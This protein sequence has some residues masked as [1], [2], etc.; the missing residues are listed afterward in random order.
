MIEPLT[1]RDLR[2][3]GGAADA[4]SDGQLVRLPMT[5]FV[6]RSAGA[7][8]AI[9]GVIW[10]AGRPTGNFAMTDAF[11]A[12]SRSRWVHRY[13]VQVLEAVQ[14]FEPVIYA[15]A[16]DFPAAAQW[17]ERLGFVRSGGEWIRVIHGCA[18][19]D[20]VEGGVLRHGERDE[21]G[22]AGVY[23]S[24]RSGRAAPGVR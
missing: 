14:R 8:E 11:R 22:V 9:G 5:G 3:W 4:W 12:S 2:E 13:A 16:D 6:R 23:G 18:S 7:I 15:T 24:W 10:F 21:G 20:G 19:G 17:L 1:W